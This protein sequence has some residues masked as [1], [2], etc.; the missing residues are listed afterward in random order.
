VLEGVNIQHRRVFPWW[1]F[2]R[3]RDAASRHPVDRRWV[4]LDRSVAILRKW[5]R[6]SRDEGHDEPRA[7]RSGTRTCPTGELCRPE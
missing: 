2:E 5:I 3:G 6:P 1:T 7:A 4:A